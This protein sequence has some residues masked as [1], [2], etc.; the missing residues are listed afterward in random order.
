[1]LIDL[2]GTN[3]LSKDPSKV[4]EYDGLVFDITEDGLYAL[5]AEIVPLAEE[6]NIFRIYV[7]LDK[8]ESVNMKL[9]ENIKDIVLEECNKP[10]D[11]IVVPHDDTPEEKYVV[12]DKKLVKV[13]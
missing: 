7:W 5:S 9:V 10:I 13:Y 6:Y 4:K 11:V 3:D 12:E 1:M 2:F 8:G